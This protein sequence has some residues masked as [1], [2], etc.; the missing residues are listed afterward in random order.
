MVHISSCEPETFFDVQ[1]MR[2]RPDVVVRGD[3]ITTTIV[4]APF[5]DLQI[6]NLHI[7]V[8]HDG[9]VIKSDSIYYGIIV[10]AHEQFYYEY[11]YEIPTVEAQGSW[12][13][14]LILQDTRFTQLA[15]TNTYFDLE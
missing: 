13:I 6:D 7:V 12:E 14:Y 11:T 15:C 8:K 4:G 9:S 5:N 3:E 2:F 1:E 10:P